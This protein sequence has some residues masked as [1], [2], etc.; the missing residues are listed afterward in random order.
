MFKPENHERRLLF[1]LLMLLLPSPHR[2]IIEVILVTALRM[3]DPSF[4]YGFDKN[5]QE[6]LSVHMVEN[7]HYCLHP[8][9]P[10][11]SHVGVPELFCVPD[12]AMAIL[13]EPTIMGYL[14]EKSI[15]TK[16]LLQRCNSYLDMSVSAVS[17]IF[18]SLHFTE[19]MWTLRDSTAE[20]DTENADVSLDA[21]EQ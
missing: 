18:S 17:S 6:H 14:S 12:E 21:R 13:T 16:E 9:L 19:S 3:T 5:D 20:D 1:Q 8:N 7:I 4:L 2:D 15:S 11:Y 10:T